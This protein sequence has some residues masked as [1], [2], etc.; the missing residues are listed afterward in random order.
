MKKILY[1]LGIAAISATT[2]TAQNS[3]SFI[4][5][6]GQVKITGISPNG[7][8]AVGHKTS[9]GFGTDE[10]A[11]FKSFLWNIDN[12]STEWKTYLDSE[13]YDKSGRFFDIN[14]NGVVCGVV[15]NKNMIK[16][17]T[18]WGET[19]TSPL[20]SAAVWKNGKLTVLGTGSYTIDDFSDLSDGSFA[21][22]I[23]NDSK[24]VAGYISVANAANLY[25]C[26]W[27][28][29]NSGNYRY[30][31]YSMPEDAMSG[32]IN[33]VSADGQIAVGWYQK[34][35]DN[36]PLTTACYWTSPK[37]CISIIAVR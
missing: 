12:N 10:T 8:Y 37:T 7:K 35:T 29:D 17:I 16:T 34:Q 9:T 22:A 27:V 32:A 25:P 6:P 1:M 11:D 31:S 21:R 30:V 4:T 36:G 33:D 3:A 26:A 18:D 28:A 19:Y 14:D 5:G 2:V 15:K 13:D 23:S 20:N 24:T